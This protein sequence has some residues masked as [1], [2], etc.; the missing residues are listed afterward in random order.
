MSVK[1]MIASMSKMAIKFM[2]CIKC[3]I[4]FTTEDIKKDNFYDCVAV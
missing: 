3:Q 2:K 1:E 4:Y